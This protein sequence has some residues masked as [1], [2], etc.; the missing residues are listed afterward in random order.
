MRLETARTVI[1]A[2]TAGSIVLLLAVYS[3]SHSAASTAAPASIIDEVAEPAAATLQQASLAGIR[4]IKRAQKGITVT[5]M[6][7]W[8]DSPWRWGEG[9]ETA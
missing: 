7:W 2:S 8:F 4:P 9:V 5:Y 1:A 3:A 6:L